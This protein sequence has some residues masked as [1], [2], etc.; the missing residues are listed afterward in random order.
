M[1]TI[2]KFFP[3]PVVSDRLGVK[4]ETA[5]SSSKLKHGTAVVSSRSAL[6][7]LMQNFKRVHGTIIGFTVNV[8]SNAHLN[9]SLS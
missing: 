8:N 5:L 7:T 2:Q 1:L 4:K 6:F 3:D 9:Y